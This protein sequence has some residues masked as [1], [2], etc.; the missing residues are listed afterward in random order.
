MIANI[1]IVIPNKERKVL[2]LFDT[3]EST[4]NLKLSAN[5]LRNNMAQR[6]EIVV[7]ALCIGIME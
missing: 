2:S 3:R 5:N 6:Y 7:L 1:P 4:A